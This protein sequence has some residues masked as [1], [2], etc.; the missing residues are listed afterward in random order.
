MTKVFVHGN[1]ECDAIW[2]PLADELGARGVSDIVRL[3]PPGFG[4]PRPAGFDATPAAYVEWLAGEVASIDGPID[5]LGHDWG[6]GH[7]MGVAATHPELIRSYAV[8][9]GALVHPDYVWH[10][11]AQAWQ[12]PEV[13]EQV[14]EAMTAGD[15]VERA[16]Q[17]A[18]MGIRADIARDVAAAVNDEMG[19]SILDL[20]RGAAQP[21]MADLGDRLAAAER[22]PSLIVI[23]SEDHFVPAPLAMEVAERLGSATVTLEGQA[24]WWMMGAEAEAADALAAFWTGLD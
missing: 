11:M 14:I 19:A 22:R 15:V 6:A 5:L 20:Y 4:A 10:D 9:C 2:G 18:M 3:S 16:E 8:D 23:A 13:G 24:H 17:F 21:Y 1:P 7:V 12:T